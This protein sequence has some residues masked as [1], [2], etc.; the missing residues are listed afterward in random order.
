MFFPA[1]DRHR[2]KLTQKA[3]STLSLPPRRR[4]AIFFDDDLAG[5]GLRLREGGS[6]NWVYQYKL[7]PKHRRITLGSVNVISPLKARERAGELHAMVRLGRD[8]AGEKAEARTRAAETFEASLRPFLARQKALLKHR[9]YLETERYL[10]SVFK[11]MHGLSLAKIERRTVASRLAEI[12]ASSGPVAADRA[13]AALSAFFTWAMREGLANGN[14]VIGTNRASA[15]VSRDRVLTDAELREI[16]NALQDDQYG[17]IARLLILTGQRREEIGGLQEAEVDL[18]HE[19]LKLPPERTKNNRAH[20]VP[21]SAPAR[22]ILQEQPRRAGRDLIFG[23]GEGA[24]QGWGRAKRALDSRILATRKA[25][26]KEVGTDLGKVKPMPAWRLHDLRRTVATRMADLGVQPHVI[27]A[28]L[29]HV[30]GHKAGVAGVY[31]RSTYIAEKA[32]ALALWAEH[33]TALVQGRTSNIVSLKM[34]A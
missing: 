25:A 30:S 22:A 9:S 11:S 18:D 20:D 29:N 14:P 13:R 19:M 32:A 7:G 12:A 33:V 31:N 3:I 34:P 28:V 6:R 8:P 1:A 26:A 15:G 23:E 24:F 4:E 16:W 17:T 5:F 27:E 2:V 21:L 10:L